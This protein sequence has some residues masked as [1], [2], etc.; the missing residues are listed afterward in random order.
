MGGHGSGRFTEQSI[1]FDLYELAEAAL[2]RLERSFYEPDVLADRSWIND[3]RGQLEIQ[4]DRLMQL[5][6]KGRLKK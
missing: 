4:R 1:A 6:I 3:K 2:T 5:A